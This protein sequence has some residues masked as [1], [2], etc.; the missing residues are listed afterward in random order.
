MRLEDG[1]WYG[2]CWCM[3]QCCTRWRGA[4][5]E[6]GDD[7]DDEDEDGMLQRDLGF[8]GV[9]VLAM[10]RATREATD[11][12]RH[13]GPQKPGRKGKGAVVCVDDGDD[14]AVRTQ[15]CW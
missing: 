10:A 9:C 5:R 4:A 1:G 12:H 15:D 6:T 13:A 11:M 2:G 3:Q 14:N 8:M 7:D